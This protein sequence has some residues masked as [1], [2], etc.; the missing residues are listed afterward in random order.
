MTLI[1]T[2]TG[3]L[4]LVICWR[5]GKLLEY[6][7]HLI[8][9][10]SPYN[11]LNIVITFLFELTFPLHRRLYFLNFLNRLSR[12]FYRLL[13]NL[14][15]FTPWRKSILNRF[16]RLLRLY[17][18][19]H[20]HSSSLHHLRLLQ[21]NAIRTFISDHAFMV[22]FHLLFT[23]HE[24]LFWLNIYYVYCDQYILNKNYLENYIKYD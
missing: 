6:L 10:C 17:R 21:F 23:V 3:Q 13:H 8:D 24:Y 22:L 19:Q 2:Q 9:I 4:K 7:R 1:T 18:W 15:I 11:R 14:F 5:G 16:I 20:R 12:L